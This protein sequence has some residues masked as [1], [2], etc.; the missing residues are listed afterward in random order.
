MRLKINGKQQEIKDCFDLE[1]LISSKGL[2][3]NNIVVEYNTK[4]IPKQ[5]WPEVILK[6]EDM[7]EIVSFV[8]GG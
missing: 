6:P 4:I 2:N 1:K 5:N 7:I 3:P 8:G